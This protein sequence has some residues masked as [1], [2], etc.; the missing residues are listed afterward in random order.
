MPLVNTPHQKRG[1]V[2]FLPRRQPEHYSTTPRDGTTV[3]K[4][5]EYLS[6]Q[7]ARNLPV[8][9]STICTTPSATG[10]SW[11]IRLIDRSLRTPAHKHWQP[12][13]WP[14]PPRP[15]G[16]HHQISIKL[17]GSLLGPP[18]IVP[19]F[20]KHLHIPQQ[21]EGIFCCDVFG[22]CSVPSVASVLVGHST[23]PGR[24]RHCFDKPGAEVRKYRGEIHDR[25]RCKSCFFCVNPVPHPF[26]CRSSQKTWTL[27]S[28]T[29]TVRSPQDAPSS[30]FN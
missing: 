16:N 14:L 12:C 21:F 11:Y 9:A 27:L 22:G 1:I 28:S 24:H 18:E 20:A 5:Q 7:Q 25:G 30:I 6:G 13:T 26:S 8:S 2:F 17:P 10:V 19:F 15:N 3:K 29:A 23:K 4:N